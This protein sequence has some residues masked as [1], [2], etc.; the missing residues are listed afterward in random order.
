MIA[1]LPDPST[2][3]SECFVSAAIVSVTVIAVASR[4]VAQRSPQVPLARRLV[5]TALVAV[6]FLA[7]LAF[8][9]ASVDPCAQGPA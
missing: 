5:L 4:S 9:F 8:V 6:A 7:V 2:W 1:S 3:E